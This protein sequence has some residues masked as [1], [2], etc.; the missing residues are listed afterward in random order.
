MNQSGDQL[1]VADLH[2]MAWL[3][4]MIK[5]SGG[6]FSE[7]GNTAIAKLESR[8]GNGFK[9]PQ[10][11]HLSEL[12]RQEGVSAATQSKLAA[13]WDAVRERASWKKVYGNGLL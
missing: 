9:L 7:D 1:S 12:Q 11:Y 8:V 3:A 13:F 2:L 6:S 10:D 4:R 5:L